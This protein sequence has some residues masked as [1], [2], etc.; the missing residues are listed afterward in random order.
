MHMSRMSSGHDSTTKL[1]KGSAVENAWAGDMTDG[2][3]E[4][5]GNSAVN[6]G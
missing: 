2:V 6:R 1:K 4:L 3:P 5:A